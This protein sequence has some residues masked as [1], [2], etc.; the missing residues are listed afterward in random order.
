MS[1]S[2]ALA[3]RYLHNFLARPK[4]INELLKLAKLYRSN[5]LRWN[6]SV[7]APASSCIAKQHNAGAWEL[8]VKNLSCLS[9]TKIS[10]PTA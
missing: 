1:R 2:Q 10:A 4:S 9:W 7:D 3:H 8:C 6:A 5:A